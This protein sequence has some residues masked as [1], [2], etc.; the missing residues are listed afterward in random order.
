MQRCRRLGTQFWRGDLA[1]RT[2]PVHEVA[3]SQVIE[4]AGIAVIIIM[5]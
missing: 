4:V 1:A 3:Q 2:F 5:Q